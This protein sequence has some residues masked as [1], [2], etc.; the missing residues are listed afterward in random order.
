MKTKPMKTKSERL[1]A[2]ADW[3]SPWLVANFEEPLKGLLREIRGFYLSDEIFRARVRAGDHR[4]AKRE[5]RE[6]L[7][8]VD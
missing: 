1:Q 7:G 4:G 2:F 5:L 6:L 8:L 3:I